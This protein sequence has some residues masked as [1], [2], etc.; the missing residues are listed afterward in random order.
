MAN[1]HPLITIF[2]VFIGLSLFGF[3]GVIFGPLILSLIVLFINLYRHDF[4][5]GSKAKPTASTELQE[6][7][8]LERLSK[9]V[10]NNGLSSLTKSEQERYEEAHTDASK[11]EEDE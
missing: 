3:W 11:T 1:I 5:P 7:K 6:T 10:Q 2:G 8:S 4:V 9:I